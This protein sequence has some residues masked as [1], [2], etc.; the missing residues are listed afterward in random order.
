MPLD[1]WF[2]RPPGV[3]REAFCRVFRP[4][5]APTS[6]R[7]VSRIIARNHAES[8]GMALILLGH[9][10]STICR[11]PHVSGFRLVRFSSL[12]C[13]CGRCQKPRSSPVFIGIPRQTT[14]FHGFPINYGVLVGSHPLKEGGRGGIRTP[15]A[16]RLAGFQ[17]RCYRPLS[18]PSKI[19]P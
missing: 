12:I 15:G 3:G 17:D 10:M 6:N 9:S 14:P 8:R 18:H 5:L 19:I 13:L 4:D 2:E 7:A 11:Q 1:R 16:L